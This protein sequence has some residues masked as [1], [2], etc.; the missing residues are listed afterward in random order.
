MMRMGIFLVLSAAL[1]ATALSYP[2]LFLPARAETF[3]PVT[4]LPIEMQNGG[5]P[6]VGRH[7]KTN[8]RQANRPRREAARR[9]VSTS[10]IAPPVAQEQNRLDSGSLTIPDRSEGIALASY[11][12]AATLDEVGLEGPADTEA[13]GGEGSGTANVTAGGNG[14]GDGQGTAMGGG[15]GAGLRGVAY[16]YNPKPK[17]PDSARK[18]GR[19]GTVV[20]RVL[21]DEDGRSKSLEVNRSSGFEAL[22]RSAIETV[23]RW[24][25]HSARYGD[26]R[27]ASWVRIP[28]EFR[29]TEAND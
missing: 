16:A 6:G 28:I 15:N 21:V 29:L 25:F 11:P 7:E 8:Q 26:K 1:H 3:F 22:D 17:Y 12:G 20:L 13:G 10:D 2:V 5:G 24:R 18:E 27:V 4:V 14:H 9:T 23:S 19:E